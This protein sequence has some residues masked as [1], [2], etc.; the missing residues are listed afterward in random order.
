MRSVVYML[1]CASCIFAIGAEAVRRGSGRL[2][3]NRAKRWGTPVLSEAISG[4]KGATKSLEIVS[5][6][7]IDDVAAVMGSDYL[8][9]A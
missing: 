2:R 9:E 7:G 1:A 5:R 3:F 8:G 4:D 6:N